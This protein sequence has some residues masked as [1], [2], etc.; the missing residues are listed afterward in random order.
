VHKKLL[1]AKSSAFDKIFNDGSGVLE[2]YLPHVNA[3]AFSFVPEWLYTG[4]VKPIDVADGAEAQV[5]FRAWMRNHID[6][7]IFA[8]AFQIKELADIV[9][10]NIGTSY[11]VSGLLP[12]KAHVDRIFKASKPDLVLRKYMAKF[13]HF[14]L[15]ELPDCKVYPKSLCSM[16]NLLLAAK[17][18]EDLF[19]RLFFSLRYDEPE[20]AHPCHD[21]MCDYHLHHKD[22]ICFFR[23]DSYCKYFPHIMAGRTSTKLPPC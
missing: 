7:H 6:L 13:L 17:E 4:N 5:R 8:E 12:F 1:C 19:R 14:L 21:M 20:A 15:T 23:G 10:D 3:D 22:S 9:T 2:Y 16:E 11:A 18:H